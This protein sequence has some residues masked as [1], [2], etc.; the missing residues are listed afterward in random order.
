M[1]DVYAATR[2]SPATGVSIHASAAP[3]LAPALDRLVAQFELDHERWCHGFAVWSGWGPFWLIS[4]NG[5]FVIQSP[6]YSTKPMDRRTSDLSLALT[7]S[8]EQQSL[9]DAAAV[10]PQPITFHHQVTA[11][12]G[13]EAAQHLLMTRSAASTEHDS[14][15][16]VEPFPSTREEPWTPGELIGFPAWHLC[17]RRTALV[18]ALTLP[19]GIA[20]VIEGD[21]I[22]AVVREADRT[23]LADGP[24]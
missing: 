6:D 14:G 17:K 1:S 13:W 9:A 12:K 21:S 7:L 3:A 2:A 22:R 18:R 15:W 5:G 23:I 24:L 16:F 20:A 19:V 11:P 8:V 10:A 4:V